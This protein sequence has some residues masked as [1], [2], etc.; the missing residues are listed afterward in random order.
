VDRKRKSKKGGAQEGR[1]AGLQSVHAFQG[2]RNNKRSERGKWPE[3]EQ[4]TFFSREGADL[5]LRMFRKGRGE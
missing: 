2:K 3:K 1:G 5:K 4:C